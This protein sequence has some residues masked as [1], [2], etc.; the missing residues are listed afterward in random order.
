MHLGCWESTTGHGVRGI[1]TARFSVTWSAARLLICCQ[2]AALRALRKGFELT[3][4]QRLSA[5]IEPACMPKLRRRPCRTPCKLP[6]AGTFF[7]TSARHLL[8]LL[9]HIIVCWWK[10]HEPRQAS[11]MPLPP[12]LF[13]YLM[14]SSRTLA[15]RENC[16]T[17]VNAVSQSIKPSWSRYR[18]VSPSAKLL[19]AAVS[20]YALF[21]AGSELVDFPS[22]SLSAAN[23]PSINTAN[24]WSSVGTRDVTMP[25][26]SGTN[27]VHEV[28]PANAL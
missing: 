20:A 25:P 1:G 12:R 18:K 19:I 26:N 16:S 23:L 8:V 14:W 27:F 24:I 3:L 11:R 21:V 4:E 9:C 22:E 17:I 7:T 2:T 6:T 28:L 10:P 5:G 13:P 15:T